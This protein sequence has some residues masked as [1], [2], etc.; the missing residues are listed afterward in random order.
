MQN[1]LIPVAV[2]FTDDVDEAAQRHARGY[3]FTIGAMGSKD[4]NF[5]NAYIRKVATP[6]GTSSTRPTHA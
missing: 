5:Y 6:G 3:A 1:L 4:K 2:E